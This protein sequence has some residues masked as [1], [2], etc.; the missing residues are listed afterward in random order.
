MEIQV[1]MEEVKVSVFADDL[2]VYT[3][4]PPRAHQGPRTFS[5]V[6]GYKINSKKKTKKSQ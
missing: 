3:S 5:K 6:S 2:T 1:G 4:D